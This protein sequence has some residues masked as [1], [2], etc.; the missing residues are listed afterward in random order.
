MA[1][2]YYWIKLKENFFRQKEI[3]KLRKIAGGDTYTVIY[4]KLLLLAMNN[5]GILCYSGI[6][7][8]FAE[9]LALEIDEDA[10]N[11]QVTLT[12]LTSCGFLEQ[13]DNNE[14]FLTQ[15]PELVGKETDSAE[16]VRQHRAK[17]ALQCNNY[18]TNCNAIETDCNTEKEKEKEKEKENTSS[19]RVA[20]EEEQAKPKQ[21]IACPYKK[22]VELYNRILVDLPSVK[23]ISDERKQNMRNRWNDASKRLK[24]KGKE[25]TEENLLDYFALFFNE[26]SKSSFLCGKVERRVGRPF[27]ANFDWIM[28]KSNFIKII[29][30]NYNDAD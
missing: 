17:K 16:R 28:K 15:I 14:M 30:G 2:T 19:L 29:E 22:V 12:F 11:V 27:M 5:N 18:V 6:E 24:D 8:T 26:V 23:E 10:D 21:E 9:E 3:K 4:F 7:S 20:E 13:L 25:P 1:K